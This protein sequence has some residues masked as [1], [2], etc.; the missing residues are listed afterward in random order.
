MNGEQI[1]VGEND[2]QAAFWIENDR[3]GCTR[4]ERNL[5]GQV[6]STQNIKIQNGEVVESEC[7]VP[8]FCEGPEPCVYVDFST[9]YHYRV[10]YNNGNDYAGFVIDAS[11]FTNDIHIG[12]ISN[13]L[14]SQ[15]RSNQNIQHLQSSNN[16]C[17][18][19]QAFTSQ[20]YIIFISA[21]I[22]FH[23]SFTKICLT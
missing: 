14:I 8:P 7:T 17:L 4:T 3:N 16:S 10:L 22:H 6:M 19:S 15:Y 12:C 11:D 9:E 21:N 13:I 23:I 2:D 20:F 5:F 1:L 18:H